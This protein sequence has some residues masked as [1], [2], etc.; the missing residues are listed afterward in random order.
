MGVL[1]SSMEVSILALL[2]P[3]V[4]VLLASSR[5]LTFAHV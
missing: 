2:R 1:L 4:L 3:V 5:A